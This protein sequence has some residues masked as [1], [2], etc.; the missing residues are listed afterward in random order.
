MLLIAALQDGLGTSALDIEDEIAMSNNEAG[1]ELDATKMSRIRMNH[2]LRLNRLLRL[3]LL[4]QFTPLI[5][6]AH[7]VHADTLQ[8]L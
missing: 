2:L 8:W 7:S 1:A 6:K 4:H 5:R 3:N